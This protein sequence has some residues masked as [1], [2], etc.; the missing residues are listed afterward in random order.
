MKTTLRLPR[1]LRVSAI[2]V[3]LAGLAGWAGGGAR[4]GWT[5]TSTVSIQRD[6]VTGID[7]PVRRTAF[8]P[9]VEVPLVSIAAAFALAGSSLLLRRR[10][11]SQLA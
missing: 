10:A 6:E 1:A 9:G 5:Q 7:Y 4:I 11:S 3:L 2:I 8:V